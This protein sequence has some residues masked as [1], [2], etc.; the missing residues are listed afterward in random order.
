MSAEIKTEMKEHVLT[1]FWG[2]DDR[3]FCV[4]VADKSGLHHIQLTMEE[5]AALCNALHKFIKEEA[6]R[7]QKLLKDY[8]AELKE[9]ERTVFREVADLPDNLMDVPYL[10]VQLISAYCPKHAKKKE[11]EG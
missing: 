11:S 9:A 7:R 8:I 4:Q 1:K 10:A 2:G 3:G 5:A 6:L